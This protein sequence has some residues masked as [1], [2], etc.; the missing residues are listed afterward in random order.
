MRLAIT[1][2]TLGA[3]TAVI[4][5]LLTCWYLP[6]VV[7]PTEIIAQEGDLTRITHIFYVKEVSNLSLWLMAVVVL[8]VAVLGCGI[9]QFIRVRQAG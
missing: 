4:S 1:Q 5:I 2:I 7:F 3:I 8:G 6:F 9:A